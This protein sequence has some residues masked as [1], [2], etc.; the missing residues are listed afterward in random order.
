VGAVDA[1]PDLVERGVRAASLE[2]RLE[3]LPDNHPASPRYGRDNRGDV[4]PLTDAEHAEHVAEVRTRLDQARAAG[5]AT[6]VQ[7]TIDPGREVWSKQRRVVHDEIIN[8]LYAA[9]RDVPCERRAVLAGGLPG[10]GKTTVLHEHASIELSR[11]LMINPDDVK[12]EMARRGLV[13]AVENLSPMEASDLVHEE[14]SHLA[15]RLAYR[16]QLD[17]KNVIWDV[18][19]SSYTSAEARVDSLHEAGYE[20]IMGVFVD[21]PVEVS[22]RRADLRHREDHDKFRAGQGLGGR[23][24]PDAAI[25][26]H[27]DAEWG[28]ANRK[29]FEQ[30]K[31]RLDRWRLYDN[32][33]DGRA[34]L[35][36]A[37]SAEDDQER[38][39]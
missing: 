1:R 29:H 28:S 32:S 19:M 21:I 20:E 11:Y 33:V 13:P 26:S 35:L 38:P 23:C 7:H 24:I 18:T 27:A 16:A 30:L 34:P 6:D 37:A 8:D 9:A 22:A 36:T 39:K 5:L 12:V 25:T 31:S 2:R 17:G 15:K 14:S 3:K 10:S 4:P